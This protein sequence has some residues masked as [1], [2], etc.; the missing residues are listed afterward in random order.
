[1]QVCLASLFRKYRLCSQV[2]HHTH[3]EL[4]WVWGRELC[5]LLLEQKLLQLLSH[6]AGSS[7]IFFERESMTEP[8]AH[9]FNQARQPTSPRDSVSAFS[10]IV[11]TG[12][13]SN[14]FLI[15]VLEIMFFMEPSPLPL[16]DF[17]CVCIHTHMCMY[18][19]IYIYLFMH[20]FLLSVLNINN[21]LT[22]EDELDTVWKQLLYNSNTRK[23][24]SDLVVI[25]L[26]NIVKFCLCYIQETWSA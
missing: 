4:R 17:V 13:H 6:L 7:T 19:Y 26:N 14:S 2:G 12:T 3:L 9:Q 1:M 22:S 23:G 15:Q 18:V 16:K 5:V 8:E 25:C 20:N 21:Y 24:A 10:S 11:I